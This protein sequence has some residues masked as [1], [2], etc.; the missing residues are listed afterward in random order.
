MTVALRSDQPTKTTPQSILGACK[1]DL[2]PFRA[3][4]SSSDLIGFSKVQRSMLHNVSQNGQ[5][6][7]KKEATMSKR[8][9]GAFVCCFRHCDLHLVRVK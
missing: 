8:Q 7:Q 3:N 5:K 2:Q 4:N 6:Q 9:K 1:G